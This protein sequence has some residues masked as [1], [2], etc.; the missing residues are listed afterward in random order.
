MAG[1]DAGNLPRTLLIRTRTVCQAV[2]L[3]LFDAINYLRQ[4]ARIAPTKRYNWFLD[5]GSVRYHEYIVKGAGIFL[6][7]LCSS[8]ADDEVFVKLYSIGRADVRKARKGSGCN[9]TKSP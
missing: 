6:F 5:L 7:I 8:E 2:L 3:E 4:A 9:R 1:N